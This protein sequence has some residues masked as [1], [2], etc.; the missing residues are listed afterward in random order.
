MEIRPINQV[1]NQISDHSKK[2]EEK[3]QKNTFSNEDAYDLDIEINPLEKDNVASKIGNTG[4]YN[5]CPSYGCG[6]SADC[7]QP[8]SACICSGINCGGT[9]CSYC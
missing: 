9:V 5:N 3:K 7:T 4:T 1:F 6:Q 2:I 8:N